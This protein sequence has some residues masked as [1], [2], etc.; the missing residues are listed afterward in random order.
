MDALFHNN[1]KIHLMVNRSLSLHKMADLS[2]LYVLKSIDIS[3]RPICLSV[4]F[5]SLYFSIHLSLSLSLFVF[6]SVSLY[7]SLSLFLDSLT[8]SIA[9]ILPSLSFTLS[10]LSPFSLFYNPN[11]SRNNN[12]VS[13]FSDRSRSLGD[14]TMPNYNVL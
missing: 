13:E 9:F 10:F 8:V 2:F 7:D 4:Y 12:E 11:N 6:L 1:A 5:I 3:I 14:T